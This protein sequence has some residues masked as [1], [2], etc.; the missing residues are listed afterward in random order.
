MIAETL[1][2]LDRQWDLRQPS[3]AYPASGGFRF[4]EDSNVPPPLISYKR[5]GLDLNS[6]SCSASQPH[7]IALGG[8]HLHAFLHDRRMTGRDRL[9][10]AGQ[11]IDSIGELSP[12]EQEL[13]GQ[14]TQ[15][16]RKFAPNGQKRMKRA[17]N[18]HITAL[19][20]SDARPDE[21][22]VSWSG[23]HIYSFDLIRDIEPEGNATPSPLRG[24]TKDRKRK[25]RN[26]GSETSLGQEANSPSRPRTDSPSGSG[27]D[28]AL[29]IRYQN[30]QSE[31][32][33][34]PG[35]AE[36]HSAPVMTESQK[37]VSLKDAY[38]SKLARTPYRRS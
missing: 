38:F 3:S 37:L 2:T 34:F 1:L 16:V 7:Y 17:E 33:R 29:R 6:I 5:Y 23:D 18:G 10:E 24:K 25:R 9:K 15:C 21:M 32:I 14:A 27:Q 35:N 11:T 36:Q 30:G 8:A 13:L 28:A 26:G 19:K 22:I 20:I 4:S 31:D 12:Q